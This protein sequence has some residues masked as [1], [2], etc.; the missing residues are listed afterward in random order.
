MI[1]NYI[2]NI[3]PHL[4]PSRSH[5]RSHCSQSVIRSPIELLDLQQRGGQFSSFQDFLAQHLHQI[6]ALTDLRRRPALDSSCRAE[7]G[8]AA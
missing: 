7:A 5:W 2:F 3:T 6:V 8:R 4:D 1:Q